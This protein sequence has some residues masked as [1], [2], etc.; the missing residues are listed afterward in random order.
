MFDVLV[1]GE[2]YSNEEIFKSLKVSNAGGIRLSL[3]DRAVRRAVVMTAVQGLHGAGEN[4]Y[5]DSLEAGG[6]RRVQ[7]FMPS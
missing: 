5:R 4:P 1:A 2:L 3:L 6:V 7:R